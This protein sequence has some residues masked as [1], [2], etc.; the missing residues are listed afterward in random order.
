M[1]NFISRTGR[2]QSWIDNPE[3][4]LPVSCTVF[5]VDDSMEG[6]E[7]IEASWR[8]VSHALRYGAG[9]AIHLSNL[10]PRGEENGKGLTASGPVSFG[11]IYSTLNEILRRGGTYKN[12]AAVLHCELRHKDALEFIQT[13]RSELPWVKRC[14]NITQEWWDACEFKDQLLHGIKAGDIWLNK[15]KH[16]KDGN[17]IYRNVC[18]EVYLPS[19]CLL[20]T[21]PSPRD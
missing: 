5:V 7:G 2:V 16:D 17:R 6:P 9:V 15:V 1:N 19:R 14:I 10:R 21:S 20:Y 13:P 18:L 4:R 8:F 11:K 12:G 3:G